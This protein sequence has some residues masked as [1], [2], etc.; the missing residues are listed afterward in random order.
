MAPAPRDVAALVF[1]ALEEDLGSVGDLSSAATIPADAQGR[2][3]LVARADGV[4]SGT[5]FVPETYG[6]VDADV[7]VSLAV[8]DGDRVKAG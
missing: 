1:A 3:V 7:Q 5:D 2:A 8:Q 6:Q 4:V